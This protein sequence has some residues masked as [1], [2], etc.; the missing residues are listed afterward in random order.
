MDDRGQVCGGQPQIVAIGLVFI[1]GILVWSYIDPSAAAT[2]P[3]E[4][5][6]WF[7]L[8]FAILAFFLILPAFAFVLWVGERLFRDPEDYNTTFRN[9][10]L[11]AAVYPVV[12]ILMTVGTVNVADKVAGW[13]NHTVYRE[14]DTIIYTMS[15]NA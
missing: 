2:K 5:I 4:P 7:E 1:I 6:D 3:A 13:T 15:Q 11:A 10:V 14:G 8:L 12:R 9:F